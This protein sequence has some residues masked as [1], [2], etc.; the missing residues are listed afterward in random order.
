MTNLRSIC[1]FL[2]I[3]IYYLFILSTSIIIHQ[4]NSNK[5]SCL[6][7]LSMTKEVLEQLFYLIHF[8]FIARCSI[9]FTIDLHL[10]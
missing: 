5:S 4:S 2:K 8:L 10:I 7:G 6:N 3:L 9:N 1:S